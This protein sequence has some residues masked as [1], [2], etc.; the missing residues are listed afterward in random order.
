MQP[1]DRGVLSRFWGKGLGFGG[2][3]GRG[4]PSKGLEDL[5]DLVRGDY[6]LSLSRFCR[7]FRVW[8]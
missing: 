5:E 7:G 3:C 8:G 1:F 6:C 2:I 4:L